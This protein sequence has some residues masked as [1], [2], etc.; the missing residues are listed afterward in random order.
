MRI[1]R[2]VLREAG[3]EI[4]P[5]YSPNSIE[6]LNGRDS[7]RLPWNLQRTAVTAWC[8]A[9]DAPEDAGQMML[10][11]KAARKCYLG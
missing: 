10:I 5:A 8:H 2:S 7:R 11:G 1:S 3:G 9:G 6:T 4:P